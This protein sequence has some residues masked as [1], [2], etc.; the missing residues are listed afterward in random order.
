MEGTEEKEVMQKCRRCRNADREGLRREKGRMEREGDRKL[1][2]QRE[3]HRTH[4][5]MRMEEKER[6]H[7]V[8]F[9]DSSTYRNKSLMCV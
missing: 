5:K 2:G 4:G 6:E 1:G 3:R 8:L 7:F 9:Q